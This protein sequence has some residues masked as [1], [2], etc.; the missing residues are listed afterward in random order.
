MS[1][2]DRC[3]ICGEVIPEGTQVCTACINKYDIEA[4]E[5]AEMAAELRD[6]ADVLKIT[7]GTDTNIRQSMQ[8]ILNIAD[9]EDAC[10]DFSA[11][12]ACKSSCAV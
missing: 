12:I 9:N 8:A 1:K 11:E 3:L 4:T 2:E 5:A 6:V 7:E 10:S